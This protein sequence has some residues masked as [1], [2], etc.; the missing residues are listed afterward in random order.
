MGISRGRSIGKAGRRQLVIVVMD[1]VVLKPQNETGIY[2][3][4]DDEGDQGN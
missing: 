2:K 1:A 3:A 4:A